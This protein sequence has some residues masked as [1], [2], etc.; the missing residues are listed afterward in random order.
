MVVFPILSATKET[1][2]AI[3]TAQH[4][5]FHSVGMHNIRVPKN[6]W[7][8]TDQWPVHLWAAEGRRKSLKVLNLDPKPKSRLQ[9]ARAILLDGIL[10]QR[11]AQT[12]SIWEFDDAIFDL[13]SI[14]IQLS[15]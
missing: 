2:K 15:L 13:W 6:G 9:D 3:G 7:C 11:Q 10:I 4:R 8:N 12:W 14:L 1:Q 5:V